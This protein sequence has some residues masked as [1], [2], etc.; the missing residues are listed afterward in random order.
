MSSRRNAPD[1][2]RRF[3]ILLPRVKFCFCN[4]IIVMQK[5]RQEFLEILKEHQTIQLNGAESGNKF[6]HFVRQHTMR[7]D[8]QLQAI[9]EGMSTKEHCELGEDLLKFLETLASSKSNNNQKEN[10]SNVCANAQPNAILSFSDSKVTSEYLS[11]LRAITKV[12][13]IFVEDE[14]RIA[15]ETIYKTLCTLH[16]LLFALGEQHEAGAVQNEISEVCELWYL[17]QRDGRENLVPQT[18]TFLLVR[19]LDYE[20]KVSDLKRLWN[21]RDALLLLDFTDPTSSE[22]LRRLLLRCLIH[23][24]FLDR[25]E[26]RKFLSYLFILYPPFVDSLHRVIK[27]A[28]ITCKRSHIEAYAEVY[29]RA[30]KLASTSNSHCLAKIEM[31]CIQELIHL[32]IHAKNPRVLKSIQ[33]LLARIVEEKVTLKS[34]EETLTRLYEPILWRSLKVANPKVRC[35][36][37]V[38]FAYVFPL[39]P[40][41]L[42]PRLMQD[43]IVEQLEHLKH[44]LQDPVPAVRVKGVLATGR[45]LSLYWEVIPTPFHTFSILYCIDHLAFDSADFRVRESVFHALQLILDN[46]LSHSLLQLHLPRLAPLIHDHSDKVRLAFVRL[47]NALKHIKSMKF[48]EIVPMEHL[49][50]R[51]RDETSSCSSIATQG[52]T[53]SSISHK[54]TLGLVSL[55][56]DTY[57]PVQKELKQWIVRCVT[58][59][60]T[61]P[62]AAVEFYRTL[63]PQLSPSLVVKFVTKIFEKLVV[64][65]IKGHTLPAHSST[66]GEESVETENAENESNDDEKRPSKRAKKLNV[67]LNSTEEVATALEIVS[68]MLNATDFTSSAENGALLHNISDVFSEENLQQLNAK[69]SEHLLDEQ[70][71]HEALQKTLRNSSKTNSFGSFKNSDPQYK[72]FLLKRMKGVVYSI[73][74]FGSPKNY[75]QL[76]KDVTKTLIE[77]RNNYLND[78]DTD[79]I[80]EPLLECVFAWNM[81]EVLLRLMNEWLCRSFVRSHNNQLRKKAEDCEEERAKDDVTLNRETLSEWRPVILF[82]LHV[83]NRLL[84][85]ESVRYATLSETQIQE[86]IVTLHRW[87]DPITHRLQY[88]ERVSSSLSSQQQQQQQFIDRGLSSK[89]K[90]KSDRFNVEYEE[91]E[92]VMTRVM[93]TY[94]KLLIHIAALTTDTKMRAFEELIDWSSAYLLPFFVRSDI[95]CGVTAEDTTPS[96]PSFFVAPFVA[97]IT[98]TVVTLTVDYILFCDLTNT[99]LVTRLLDFATTVVAHYLTSNG[100]PHYEFVW[101]TV[102]PIWKLIYHLYYVES[103]LTTTQSPHVHIPHQ[104]CLQFVLTSLQLV[105][106]MSTLSIGSAFC[107]LFFNILC[108]VCCLRA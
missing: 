33:Q 108:F 106:I 41:N 92:D 80:L 1:Q 67:R 88:Y 30:W 64:P 17:Q 77:L 15:P 22:S 43:R 44:L 10:C 7:D 82:A 59:I 75:H 60:Q 2:S 87:M 96:S 6:V 27:A 101:R 13:K 46:H 69:L 58:L 39:L 20:S 16:N 23:P 70:N 53:T 32:S 97:N 83:L 5:L 71:K 85:R 36:A 29:L 35:N 98:L 78:S 9:I 12:V 31:N 25:E 81:S 100:T 14:K 34:F 105:N 84:A 47:L 107:F 76:G 61:D 102:A 68:E 54:I 51:L 40:S 104:K 42:P 72:I 19:A 37:A 63:A 21:L 52:P 89:K 95:K 90:P 55:L 49:L 26:G 11:V 74:K 57:F 91:M 38:Q 18:I 28:L 66:E 4:Y 86:I 65:W 45:I 94:Y 3:V 24:L 93:T 99:S 79:L 103:E 48:W 56:Q 62:R 8:N 73:A 50:A